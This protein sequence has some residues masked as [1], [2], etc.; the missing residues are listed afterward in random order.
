MRIGLKQS[1]DLNNLNKLLSWSELI[2]LST[3]CL[4][5]DAKNQK[6]AKAS[7]FLS[8]SDAVYAVG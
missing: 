2:V 8:L 1:P 6:T 3:S 7:Y 4:P 5:N